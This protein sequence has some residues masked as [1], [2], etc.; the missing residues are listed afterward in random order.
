MRL[1]GIDTPETV[2]PDK[3]VQEG[4]KVASDYTKQQLT[5][6]TVYIEYDVGL[7]DQY[8]RLLGYLYVES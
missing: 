5:D 7:R 8:G 6:I 2:H 3:P 4:G 1:I